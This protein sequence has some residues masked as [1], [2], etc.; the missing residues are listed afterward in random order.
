[1]K[2][3]PEENLIFEVCALP[4]SNPKEF[5]VELSPKE[6]TPFKTCDMKL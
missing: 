6:P 2:A 3:L 4:I 5:K 1:M